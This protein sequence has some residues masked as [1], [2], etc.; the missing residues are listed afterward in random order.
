MTGEDDETRWSHSVRIW[1]LRTRTGK[2]HTLYSVRWMVGGQEHHRSFATYAL[3]DAFRAKLLTHVQR[4][5]A[6][7]IE[8]GLPAP[9]LREARQ[10]SWYQHVC[11]YVDMKWPSAAPKSRAGIAESLATITPA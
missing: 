1:A 11:A 9:M 7:D 3:A 6:F 4:G 10:R 8:T 2:K 5:S